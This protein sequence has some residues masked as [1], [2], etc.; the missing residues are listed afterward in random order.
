MYKF[1]FCLSSRVSLSFTRESYFA[2]D[3]RQ[4]PERNTLYAFTTVV[5]RPKVLILSFVVGTK[6][7]QGC[8]FTRSRN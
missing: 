7:A 1:V 2:E 6:C 5:S 3:T 4:S 8:A